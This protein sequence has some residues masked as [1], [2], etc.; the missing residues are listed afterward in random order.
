MTRDDPTPGAARPPFPPGQ[1][2][3][4]RTAPV[5]EAFRSSERRRVWG[6]ALAAGTLTVLLLGVLLHP[7]HLP[8]SLPLVFLVVP[9]AQLALVPLWRA[10]GVYRYH[11]PAFF[12]VARGEREVE[13]HG[14]TLYDYLL[15]MRWAERGPRARRTLLRHYLVGVLGVIAD[16]E[17]GSIHPGARLTGTSY[18]FSGR[19]ARRLGF[20]LEPAGFA[21]RLHL[22]LDVL[23]LVVMY[24]YVRGRPSLPHFWK[25]RKAVVRAAELARHRPEVERLLQRLDTR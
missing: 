24:S 21:E 22:L 20:T 2:A 1:R 19:T 25:T 16:V 4:P 14:G 12:V 3:E 9:A 17:R 8:W 18:V 7:G 10:T 6:I 15:G 5:A 11:S 23:S 13:L